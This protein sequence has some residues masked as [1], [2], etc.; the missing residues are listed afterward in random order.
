[1]A[2]SDPSA[3]AFN[4]AHDPNA[5]Q[6]PAYG[7]PQ[8]F[9]QDMA[10]QAGQAYGSA[11]SHVQAGYGAAAAGVNQG[12]A[13]MSNFGGQMMGGG[14]GPGGAGF[15][16]GGFGGMMGGG[17]EGGQVN[18]TVPLILAIV[19]LFPCFNCLFGI[20]ALILVILG[21]KAIE[22]GNV[23]DGKKKVKLGQI[24]AIV[25]IVLSL[26]GTIVNVILRM[27]H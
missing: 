1:M 26:L 5:G 10:A 3:F 4:Q 12:L 27:I 14:G 7:Q 23:E 8:S 18:T 6:A 25:G 16:G 9:G 24:L 19:T 2:A 21:K 22:Q 13:Q 17:G 20:P 15:G 11:A